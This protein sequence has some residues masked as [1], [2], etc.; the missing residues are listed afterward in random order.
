MFQFGSI[1]RI[2]LLIGCLLAVAAS[3]LLPATSLAGTGGVNGPS[4]DPDGVFT[5]TFPTTPTTGMEYNWTSHGVVFIYEFKNGAYTRTLQ[6]TT[7]TSLDVTVSANGT[8]RYD[9]VWNIA[10]ETCGGGGGLPMM[11]LASFGCSTHFEHHSLGSHTVTVDMS[12]VAP[13]NFS[14]P[15][16]SKNG[17]VTLIWSKPAQPVSK[18]QYRK[19]LSTATTWGSAVDVVSSAESVSK[20]VSG[21]TIGLWDFQ[22]RTC[23]ALGCSSYSASRRTTVVRTPGTP[24]T[25]SYSPTSLSCN[26]NFD[27]KWG[28]ASGGNRYEI[29]QSIRTD[30]GSWS[31]W[32]TLSN[33][34]TT[35]KYDRDGLTAGRDYKYA[36][37]ARYYL[38]GHYSDWSGFRYSGVL[39]KPHCAPGNIAAPTFTNSNPLTTSTFDVKWSAA[40][41]TVSTYELQHQS[42]TAGWTTIQNT[43]AL[44]KQLS[45]LARGQHCFKVRAVN[46]DDEGLYSPS[47]C[48]TV[49]YPRPAVSL[50][51][52][53]APGQSTYNSDV[54]GTYTIAWTI[55]GQALTSAS[56]L[57]NGS[58]QSVLNRLNSQNDYDKPDNFGSGVVSHGY[59][60]KACN[61][62]GCTSSTVYTVNIQ[63]W[64]VP[65][66]PGNFT[67]NSTTSD[68][69]SY[70]LTWTAPPE[71]VDNYVIERNGIETVLGGSKT[72]HTY[73]GVPGNSYTHKIRACAV[74]TDPSHCNSTSTHSVYVRLPK[75][76]VPGSLRIKNGPDGY[77][78]GVIAWNDISHAYDYDLVLSQRS[79]GGQWHEVYRDSGTEMP[80]DFDE[81]GTWEYKVKACNADRCSDDSDVLEVTIELAD[82][83]FQGGTVPDATFSELLPESSNFHGVVAGS[84]GVNGGAGSYSVP[85]SLPPG[86]NNV[87]P[88]VSL[89]YSSR[90]GN[91]IAGVGWS[92]SYG[93]VI[94][95]CQSTYAQDGSNYIYDHSKL[96]YNGQRMRLLDGTYGV[97]GAVYRTEQDNFIK[98]VE[99][100]DG[101]HKTFTAYH[102]SGAQEHFGYV[103]P[104]VSSVLNQSWHLQK[105]EKDSGRNTIE[106]EYESVFD[107]SGKHQGE[108]LISSIYYTGDGSSRGNRQVTFNYG[109]RTDTK[110]SYSRYGKIKRTKRLSDIEVYYGGTLIREYALDYGVPSETSGRSLLRE[111]SECAFD[112]LGSICREPTSFEW[113]ENPIDYSVRL[114]A[115]SDGNEIHPGPIHSL[116][117]ITPHGDRNGDGVRDW[118]GLF[119]D[120]EGNSTPNNFD[121]MTC[122]SVVR[123]FGTHCVEGDFDVDGKTDSWKVSNG[124]LQIGYTNDASD[125]TNWTGTDIPLDAPEPGAGGYQRDSLLKVA[126]YN[127]DGWPDITLFRYNNRNPEIYLYFHTKNTANPF[128]QS[129]AQLLYAYSTVG[130][131]CDVPDGFGECDTRSEISP[132]GDMDGNGLPDFAILT[133]YSSL[134]GAQ[135]SIS[136]LL[137]TTQSATGRI[138]FKSVSFDLSQPNTLQRSYF[139]TFVDVNADGLLD[140]V[141][142]IGSS[143]TTL[144]VRI[145][146][147][148]GVF[149]APQSLGVGIATRNYYTNGDVLNETDKTVVQPLYENSIFAMDVDGDGKSELLMPGAIE[150]EGC[151]IVY[152]EGGT[153]WR[154][155]SEL[156]GDYLKSAGA[157]FHF[158]TIPSFYNTNIYR[159]KALHFGEDDD[160]QITAEYRSTDLIAGANNFEVIDAFGKGLQDLVFN[161]GCESANC[162]MNPAGA[163][164]VLNGKP[165]GIYVNYNPGAAEQGDNYQPVDLLSGVENGL[166]AREEWE[167][168]P[169]SSSDERFHS[170]ARP[171]YER[172]AYLDSLDQATQDKHFEF[173]S[174]MYVVA[175]HRTTNGV[176]GMNAR[177]YRYKGAVFNNIGRGF[178]GFHSIIEENLAT[179]IEIQSDFHQIFPLAGKLHRLRKWADGDRLSDSVNVNA[180]EETAFSWQFWAAGQHGSP[181]YVDSLTDTWTA[182][183]NDPYFVGPD[184]QT[185]TRRTLDVNVR[186]ELYTRTQSSTF[187]EWGNVL[188]A[189]SEYSEPGNRHKVRSSTES[190]YHP[191]DE[192]NWW[193]NKLDTQT[194]TKPAIENRNGVEIQAGT[195]ADHSVLVDYLGWDESLR[196]PTSVRTEVITGGGIATGVTT[197]YTAYGLPKKVTTSADGEAVARTIETTVFSADNYFPK[198]VKNALGHTVTTVTNPKYG[199]PDSVT[200]ANTLTTTY[201]YDA[202]GRSTKVVA[203]NRS[204]LRAAPDSFSVVQ[205]CNGTC[206]S[207]SGA[208]YKTIQ[209]QAGTPTVVSYH[210]LVGRAI[211]QEVQGFDSGNVIATKTTY[212]ALGQV[213]FESV[214]YFVHAPSNIGTRYVTYDA[215]GRLEHK[216]IDQTN[217]QKLNIRYTHEYMNSFTTQVNANGR[218]MYRTYNGL[219]QLIDTLDAKSGQTQFAYDG[220]GNPIVIQDA[221]Q[222]RITA[223]YNALGQK[224]WVNDPNMGIK[225]F[226]YTGYGEVDSETDAKLQVTSFEYDPL[227]RLE[228][229]WVDGV[230]EAEWI[231]DTAANGTGLPHVEKTSDGDFTRTYSY[232]VLSRPTEVI[233]GIDGEQFISSQHY[234]S[235]YGRAKGLTYPGDLTLH[236]QYNANG[237]RDRVSN[238]ASGYQYQQLIKVDAR[239]QWTEASLAASNYTTNRLFYAETGQMEGSEF[240]NLLQTHQT[241]AYDYDD[242]GNLELKTVWIPSASPEVNSET[243]TYDALNRLDFSSRTNGASIDYEYDAVGNLTK[244]D[245]F[246]SNYSY[247][248]GNGGPNAVQGVTLVGGGSKT[249]GYDAN[250][251]RTHENGSQ[252]IW[253]NAFNK[254][255]HIKKDGADLLF[256]YGADQMR[257]KQIN[258]ATGKTTLYIDKLFERISGGG[259]TQY[260]H[261]VEDIAVITIKEAG[262]TTEHQIGFTHRDHLGS[263]VAIADHKGNLHE[264]HDYDPF[265]KPRQGNILDKVPSTLMSAF[266]TRGFTDHEYLDDAELIHMN[267]RAYDYN[268]GRFLSVDP[269]IMEPGNSQALNPYSY[270][271]NNPLAGTDPSGYTAQC[272]GSDSAGK[273]SRGGAHSEE[274]KEAASVDL[275]DIPIDQ[276]SGVSVAKGGKVILEMKDGSGVEVDGYGANIAD[277]GNVTIGQV[278]NSTSGSISDFGGSNAGLS[279]FVSAKSPLD[280]NVRAG[281]PIVSMEEWGE[282]AGAGEDLRI[283]NAQNRTVEDLTSALSK[284]YADHESNGINDCGD[285]VVDVAKELG[286]TSISNLGYESSADG[287]IAHASSVGT[288]LSIGD[289]SRIQG[290]VNSGGIVIM[291]VTSKGAGKANGHVAIVRPDAWRGSGRWGGKVPVVAHRVLGGKPSLSVGSNHAFAARYKSNVVFYHVK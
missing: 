80:F 90:G 154:C 74:D 9:V 122:Y 20:T 44:K 73:V 183:A 118:P 205:R 147:A 47:S 38:N 199:S 162:K 58:S 230:K 57:E 188:T 130:F 242:F 181:V 241:M 227:G 106:Y 65:S 255:T 254:P 257:Y 138:E 139:S 182:A 190:L 150:V 266:T 284:V 244:K 221:N 75:P 141:G 174:S 64:P 99:G 256:S 178:Q 14:V 100:R 282:S 2:Y 172:G 33:S 196:K 278:G 129:D 169:L 264:V 146:E 117:Q 286:V 267:G 235:S 8:Y 261:F 93:S 131:G 281:D 16:N 137:L 279:E 7:N 50:Q 52:N 148:N 149:S 219:Q 201:E 213:T 161:Y 259:E 56:L 228:S 176:G 5:I 197:E 67:N 192:T 276:I 30:G 134:E 69:T 40:T 88:S 135:L 144:Y 142:W 126:D 260:R 263:T 249:Y 121:L 97:S 37:R 77:G 128:R 209:M 250:G 218:L 273:C 1:R 31:G 124:Y 223:S 153:E 288:A 110:T 23:N 191:A 70:T 78:E 184:T 17:S 207:A 48:V 271:L 287:I 186:N 119:V 25:I 283:A 179:G 193:L 177:Q 237:Y 72:S 229:R 101:G 187:D 105:F 61:P 92:L 163:G 102:S 290:V 51:I 243:Y 251:N 39:R 158:A 53:D 42:P 132:M 104:A 45:N 210:D 140:W 268:L 91:G 113:L 15:S 29:R 204:G 159:Y 18:Y 125:G 252:N 214:P 36:V 217:G 41:G 63:P 21:L 143:G 291:G 55:S 233:T 49:K 11:M 34:V 86:R 19:K 208:A 198:T 166:G 98:I 115:D 206:S 155:G 222:S 157:A 165:E 274:T 109:D 246:A 94:S 164:S 111:I 89:N 248:G 203:P 234:D 240:K 27:V 133:K 225:S 87:A 76:S 43:S 112:A 151:H 272:M 85:I 253:Y 62:D 120:A 231:F 123:T 200:D 82:W 189:T 180:F 262:A 32:S 83:A 145:N 108:V 275:N 247:S 3:L 79:T 103:G 171:F 167:Y 152:H 289:P 224:D 226:T 4:S 96:C 168:R 136:H 277:N 156:Y 107:A 202:F 170:D 95:K 269:F 13:G 6:K 265:G 245:D 28:A 71:S 258:Q 60:A 212:N 185:S 116:Q 66:A 35:T 194:I 280:R 236:Y 175:E 54:Y 26:T 127:G 68:S 216:T 239:G 84:G 10:V 195:D 215:L 270:I 160:G 173:A 12:P 238:A 232:D 46:V 114:L 24:G 220:S 59:Q 22:V 285:Y 211:Q 81:S